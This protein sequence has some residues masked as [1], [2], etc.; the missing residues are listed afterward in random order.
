M[1]I[2]DVSESMLKEDN[3]SKTSRLETAKK[4]LQDVVL[5]LDTQKTNLS[6]SSFGRQCDVKTE[7][8]ATANSDY[9][10]QKA[11]N[12][13]AH[14]YTPLAKAIRN[15]SDLISTTNKTTNLVLISD[16]HETCG[17]DPC[18][19]M[20][21]LMAKHPNVDIKTFI[22]GYDLDE[23]AKAQFQCLGG[24]YF[25]AKNSK[26]L[27]DAL[28]AIATDI[29]VS[30]GGWEGNVYNFEINFDLDSDVVKPQYTEN[31]QNLADYMIKSGNSMQVQGHTDSTG[32]AWY[33][34]Q[35][36]QRRADSVRTKLIELGVDASKIT[37]IG[38]GEDRPKV[39]NNS[40]ENREINRRVEAHPAN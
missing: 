23:Y 15:A 2:V 18:K 38:Y 39:S 19:E 16:G 11:Q 37:A 12:L 3:V 4:S 13:S 22:I 25:D 29:D 26:D 7:V 24:K 31:V 20:A 32:E 6:L 30:K 14:G 8:K 1:F 36:S 33:N 35:L 21:A 28:N 34:Q 27:S 10:I 5:T 9:F 40:T 17:G